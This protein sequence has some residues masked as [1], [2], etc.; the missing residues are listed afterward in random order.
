MVIGDGI[1]TPCISGKTVISL[2]LYVIRI[3][4]LIFRNFYGVI[5]IVT[6]ITFASDSHVMWISIVI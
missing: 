5:S 3:I 4:F 2:F 1:L 6:G